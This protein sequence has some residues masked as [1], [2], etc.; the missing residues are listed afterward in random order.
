MGAIVNYV[1]TAGYFFGKLLFLLLSI[2]GRDS[3]LPLL[4]RNWRLFTS[5]HRECL[6]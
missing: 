5:M 2:R 3:F 1:L 4:F 6:K